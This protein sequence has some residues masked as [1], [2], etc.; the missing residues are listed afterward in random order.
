MT[1]ILYYFLLF[2]RIQQRQFRSTWA[3]EYFATGGGPKPHMLFSLG[4]KI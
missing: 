4:P 3:A 1:V 2:G